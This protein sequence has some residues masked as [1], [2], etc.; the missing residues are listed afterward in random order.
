MPSIVEFR[1]P[2]EQFAFSETATMM[3][4]LHIAIERFVAQ[5]TKSAVAFMWVSTNDFDAFEM[6]A[7][8]DPSVDGFSTLAEIDEK[9]FYRM[10]WGADIEDVLQCL[11]ET[12]GTVATATLSASSTSWEVQLICPDRDSVS[13]IY[14]YGTEKGLS[15]MVDSLYEVSDEEVAQHDRTDPISSSES[16]IIR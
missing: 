11:H 3:P 6:A 9:R 4:D 16:P 14:E 7:A 12:N 2:V 10:Q 13:E 15:L 5:S 8:E 1:L